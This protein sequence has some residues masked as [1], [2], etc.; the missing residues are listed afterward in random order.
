MGSHSTLQTDDGIPLTP[1]EGVIIDAEG[2]PLTQAPNYKDNEQKSSGFKVISFGKLPWPVAAI[3]VIGLAIFIP[4]LIL[5]A[6]FFLALLIIRT[7][8]RAIT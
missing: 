7:L 2:R 6:L 5:G 3:A 4:I 1:K 8:F